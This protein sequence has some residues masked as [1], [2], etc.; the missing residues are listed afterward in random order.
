MKSNLKLLSH[1]YLAVSSTPVTSANASPVTG[2]SS[3]T[4]N[5]T[6]DATIAEPPPSVSTLLEKTKLF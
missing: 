4:Q 5:E 2:R 6:Y 3:V 1:V